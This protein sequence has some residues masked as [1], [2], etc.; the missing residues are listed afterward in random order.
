MPREQELLD[1]VGGKDA[2][3]NPVLGD[4][5]VHVTKEVEKRGRTFSLLR[6]YALQKTSLIERANDF[7]VHR[8][9]RG[10]PL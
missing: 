10:T 6:V 8:D 1:K 4:I 3:G 5:G 2:S 9:M 7:K